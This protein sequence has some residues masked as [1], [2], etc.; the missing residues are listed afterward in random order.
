MMTVLAAMNWLA[1]ALVIALVTAAAIV[2]V[3]TAIELWRSWR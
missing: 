2:L 3:H 1:W